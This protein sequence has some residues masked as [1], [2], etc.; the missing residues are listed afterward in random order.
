MIISGSYIWNAKDKVT[1]GPRRLDCAEPDLD[2]IKEK[3]RLM[4]LIMT[5]N[6]MCKAT[7]WHH[8]YEM[9]DI[10]RTGMP[11]ACNKLGHP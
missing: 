3:Q 4:N 6:G 2:P 11:K 8:L 7:C 1:Y 9:P 5:E 10:F